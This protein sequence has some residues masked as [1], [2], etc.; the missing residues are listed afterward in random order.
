MSI[1]KQPSL[2]F[3]LILLEAHLGASTMKP[4]VSIGLAK[5]RT[6]DATDPALL[7]QRLMA[8]VHQPKDPNH[9]CLLGIISLLGRQPV[10]SRSTLKPSASAGAFPT[11]GWR[12][13]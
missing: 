7:V 13:S 6:Q 10:N 8:T 1:V 12:T 11:V 3:V 4:S 5:G 9:H 2:S